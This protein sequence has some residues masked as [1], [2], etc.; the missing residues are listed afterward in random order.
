[1]A[2]KDHRQCAYHSRREADRC[3]LANGQGT[4]HRVQVFFH[5]AH[6]PPLF[7]SSTFI[8]FDFLGHLSRIHSSLRSCSCFV[9]YLSFAQMKRRSFPK[10][11]LHTHKEKRD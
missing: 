3:P 2:E 11:P 5:R 10:P 8:Y 1:M 9:T 7:V 6:L 4:L